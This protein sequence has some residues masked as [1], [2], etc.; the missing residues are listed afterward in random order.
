MAVLMNSNKH[1]NLGLPSPERL[2]WNLLVRTPSGPGIL[3]FVER[4][5]S[6]R[7]DFLQSG[8]LSACPLLG[9][10]SS[11]GVSSIRG[12]TVIRAGYIH[13]LTMAR[14]LCMPNN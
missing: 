8:V 12:L 4:L 6:F 9:G 5:S 13:W 1:T 11:F 10:L 2:Q 3:S 7:G 14:L